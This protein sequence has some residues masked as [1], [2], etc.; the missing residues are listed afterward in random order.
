[1]AT[2]LFCASLRIE[3]EMAFDAAHVQKPLARL[4]KAVLR[5]NLEDPETVHKL[6]TN[7]R[8]VEAI[9]G[10]IDVLQAGCEKRLRKSLARIRGA[11]GKVRDLDVLTGKAADVTAD[12]ERSCQIRILEHLVSQRQRKAKKLA[13]RLKSDRK[14]VR[15]DLRRCENRVGPMLTEQNGKR[16]E[17]QAAAHALRLSVELQKFAALNRRNLHEYRKQGKMLRYVLQM[18]KPQDDRL[19]DTLREMQDAIGEWHDWE[20]LLTIARKIVEHRNCGFLRELQL[21]ADNAYHHALRVANATRKKLS[22]PRQR[23]T[24]MLKIANAAAEFAA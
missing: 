12:G 15:R 8:R 7:T 10:A 5:K 18:A 20:E 6:R 17:G 3:L 1:M 22:N 21:E 24:P 9:L 11:A 13:A 2:A 14:H 23:R 19:L 16:A 4:R